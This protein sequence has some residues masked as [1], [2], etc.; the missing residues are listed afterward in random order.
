[1]GVEA[2]APATAAGADHPLMPCALRSE[3]PGAPEVVLGVIVSVRSLTGRGVLHEVQRMRPG[4]FVN[5]HCGHSMQLPRYFEFTV[6]PQGDLY[7]D[8]D[9]RGFLAAFATERVRCRARTAI[10]NSRPWSLVR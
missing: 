6:H 7:N 2:P 1:M 10:Q 9:V 4:G 5:P 8:R 3:V